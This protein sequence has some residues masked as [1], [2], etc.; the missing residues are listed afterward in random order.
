LSD[1]PPATPAASPGPRKRVAA[2]VL[3][4]GRS[5]RTS[6]ENKLLAAR[7]GLPLI[8]R[9]VGAALD[10]PLCDV[11]VVTGHQRAE[12]ERALGAMH[13]ARCVFNPDYAN[14]VS[15]SIA[16]GIGAL[17]PDVDAAI[18]CLGDMPEIRPS[19]LAALIEAFETSDGRAV[20][21][22]HYQGQRGNPVLWPAC[23]FGPLQQLRGDVGGRQLLEQCGDRLRRVEMADAAILHDV[24]TPEALAAMRG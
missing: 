18:V 9:I 4:A 13:R 12:I 16:A 6:P 21:V 23:D 14:G 2:V 10:S 22:P 17:G 15:N 24:D 11:V 7:G 19:H 20:C 8:A 5:S 1:T 3:A